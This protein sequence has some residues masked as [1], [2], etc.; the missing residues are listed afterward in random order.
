MSVQYISQLMEDPALFSLLEE[1]PAWGVETIEFSIGDNLDRGTEAVRDYRKRMGRWLETRPLSVHGPFLDLNPGSFDSL[2]REA[3]LRRCRQAYRAAAELGAD[4]IVFH[5]GFLPAT[6]YE[7]GWPEKAAEFWKEFLERTDG[8]LAVHLENV[9]DLHWQI[10]R[11]ILD[12]VGCP[13]FTACLDLGHIWVFSPQRPEEWLAGLGERTGHLHLHDNR[14][15]KDTHS[16][17]GQGTIP[18][19]SVEQAIRRYCPGVS[20]TIENSLPEQAR[21]S[22]RFLEERVLT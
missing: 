6:C 10:L 13:H 21:E 2:I 3:T 17:L 7:T 20:I 16:A 14:G 1:H 15:E 4:R 18:W 19:D 12:L 5:T 11:R 9:M 22:L 8:S